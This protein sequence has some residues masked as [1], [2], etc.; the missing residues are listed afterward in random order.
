MHKTQWMTLYFA[1]DANRWKADTP[2][3]FLEKRDKPMTPTPFPT[4]RWRT[5]RHLA[6]LLTLA[7][8]ASTALAAGAPVASPATAAAPTATAGTGKQRPNIVF[9]LLDDAGFSDFGAYGSE[10]NTPHIDQIARSGVRFTNFHTAS[11]CE[12][13]RAM[14]HSG[15]DHHRA[16][17]GTLTAVMADNQ[18]G[19][20]WMVFCSSRK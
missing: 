3:D 15:V 9:I 11:T 18:N 5:A 13:S 6:S 1:M 20:N 17:A 16:G 12:S 8:A 4:S 19:Q 7:F 14:L 2:P 10:I